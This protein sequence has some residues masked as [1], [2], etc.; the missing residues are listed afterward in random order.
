MTIQQG[1]TSTLVWQV[2][3]AKN[4]S[5][6]PIV[7]SVG[8]VGTQDV[9]LTQT[10]QFT[11][12]ATN[13]FGQ[14]QAQVTVTVTPPPPPP[15]IPSAVITSFT[16]N[17]PVSPSPGSVVVLTCLATNAVTVTINGVGP[18]DANNSVKVTPLVDTTYTCTAVGKDDKPATATLL[19]KVTQPPP[20][21]PPP[22]VVIIVSTNGTCTPTATQTICETVVRQVQLDLSGSTSPAGNNPLS[23][24]TNSRNTAAAVLNPTSAKPIVELSELFGDYF[25]DVTVTDSKGNKT[26]V[27]L[28][29]RLVVTRR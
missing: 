12:T 8:L 5:I 29:V 7:G 27:T 6:A 10:T 19:V 28:D 2:E 9:T 16:A 21:P 25:F 1:G 22:P 15:P 26:T 24:F 13:D 11:L 3:N 14:A 17:P 20:P 18:V 23:F 4:I